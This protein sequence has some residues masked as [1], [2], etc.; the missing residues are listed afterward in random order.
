ML[1][2]V[3]NQ[4]K[5]AISQSAP[6]KAAERSWLPDLGLVVSSSPGP[7]Q[8]DSANARGWGQERSP[9]LALPL[10]RS[11]MILQQQPQK[12]QLESKRFSEDAFQTL[13]IV[14]TAF[15]LA[16][17]SRLREQAQLGAAPGPELSSSSM[18][19]E[20][21]T[22]ERVIPTTSLFS[23]CFHQEPALSISALQVACSGFDPR[24]R[25][26]ALIWILVV[27]HAHTLISLGRKIFYPQKTWDDP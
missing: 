21:G 18:P 1:T 8:M 27:H 2:Q 4:V 15:Y 20:Q 25:I 17:F 26:P 7:L 10:A 24:T 6:L 16:H 19:G 13:F 14:T 23:P 12:C 5:D 22:S 3:G 11:S 9:G